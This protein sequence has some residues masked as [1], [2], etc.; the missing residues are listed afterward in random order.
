MPEWS[1]SA[2]AHPDLETLAAYADGAVSVREKAAVEA[3]LAGCEECFDVV[4][5]LGELG[6]LGAIGALGAKRAGAMGAGALGALG[7]LDAA[8]GVL[9]LAAVF[10][11][12]AV[13]WPLRVPR[14]TRS[15]VP[16]TLI[17]ICD[18]TSRWWSASMMLTPGRLRAARAAVVCVGAMAM[19]T[20]PVA[21]RRI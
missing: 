15:K 2:G 3:H 21:V 11:R 18:R 20:G 17:G 9:S 19:R 7:A 16:M 1:P 12:G 8:V 4:S 10:V 14:R 5:E 6:A 13:V